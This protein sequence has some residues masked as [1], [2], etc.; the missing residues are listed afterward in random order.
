MNVPSVSRNLTPLYATTCTV[1]LLIVVVSVAGLVP[2]VG[3]DRVDAKSVFGIT[4][5]TAGILV[6]GFRA[7]DALNLVVG[8]PILLGSLWLARRGTLI[9]LLFGPGALFYV[10]YTYTQ[11]LVG[12]PFDLLFLPYVAL[13]AVSAYT[14]IGLVLSIDG[15]HVRQ[16]LAN[17]TP[18]RTIGGILVG[19][20]LLTL[21]Q[22]AS[23][24]I[25]TAVAGGPIDPVARQVWIADL[26]L[27]VPAMLL[28]GVLLWRRE[29]LGYVAGAGLLLQY[30]MTPL[31]LA[32][33]L[34]LQPV[35][36]GAPIDVATVLALLF[37]SGVC[38]VPLG[39]FARG[40]G[41]RIPSHQPA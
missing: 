40:S 12:A 26:V 6:P 16:R 25:V 38:F 13:V 1:A 22:D 24:A 15:E 41:A 17:I 4:S 35:L 31:V 3:G 37:F 27:E 39:Y 10:L 5:S 23:G 11:Y 8:L 7:H 30:G 32:I 28:G 9:G 21:A 20:A 2:A 14:T 18:A 36:T 19:L 29:R 34:V 33:M